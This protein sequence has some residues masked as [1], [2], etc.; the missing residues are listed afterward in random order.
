MSAQHS[1]QPVMNR[2]ENVSYLVLPTCTSTDRS[3]PALKS[4]QD[5]TFTLY[6]ISTHVLFWQEKHSTAPHRRRRVIIESVRAY[7]LNE[8]YRVCCI[9]VPYV[10]M[11]KLTVYFFFLFFLLE[12]A[13]LMSVSD[14]RCS[15]VIFRQ[16]GGG[17][18]HY[19][20]A[21][22]G[23]KIYLLHPLCWASVQGHIEKQEWKSERI[24]CNC[25]KQLM[26]TSISVAGCF[27]HLQVKNVRY[28]KLCFRVESAS[29]LRMMI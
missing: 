23:C 5:C 8:V 1:Y 9:F 27:D 17:E 15:G 7:V 25:S 24:I 12:L 10:G 28:P 21:G 2:M 22:L 14:F 20:T 18:T 29:N 3:A 13:C 19:H 16:A 11:W 26:L 4:I 6:W